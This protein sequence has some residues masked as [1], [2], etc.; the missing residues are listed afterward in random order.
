VND[1]SGVMDLNL[2][3]LMTADSHIGAVY[4][5][6]GNALMKAKRWKT[7]ITDFQFCIQYKFKPGE[8]FLFYHKIGQCY[9]K[10]KFYSKGVKSFETALDLLKSSDLGEKSK[11]EF[12]KILSECIAKFK[13]KKDDKPKCPAEFQPEKPNKQDPIVTDQV[14]VIETI[15]MG[16]NAFAKDN[17][18]V[19][20]VL[21]VVDT[22]AAHLNPDTPNQVM[23]YCLHC[24]IG[25]EVP[26]PCSSCPRVIFC[27][28]QCK[29][30]AE[31]SYHKYECELDLYN[32]RINDSK[33][34]CTIFHS[35]KILCGQPA[36]FWIKNQKEFVG[37]GWSG[38]WPAPVQNDVQRLSLL[39]QM[40]Q[41]VDDVTSPTHARHSLVTIFL[42]RSLR[43]TS[44]YT[45]S[46]LETPSGKL[47]SEEI[48]LGKLIYKLR[49]IQ[50]MNSHPVWG[51][52][53]NQKDKIGSDHIGAGLYSAIGSYFNSDCNPNTFR[54]N[55]GRKMLLIAAKNI[56]KGEEVMD[57]YCIHF[58][59]LPKHIRHPWIKE[60]Y[61]FDCTCPACENDWPTYSKLPKD[62]PNKKVSDKLV[63][64]EM[65]NLDLVGRGEFDK[66]IESHKQEIRLI[67]NAL[68]T[69]HQLHVTISKSFQ[70]CWWKKVVLYL[71]Q[72]YDADE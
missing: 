38:D 47:S 9:V 33:D 3:I 66:A 20:S 5:H 4:F 54:I 16:R 32:I 40:A 1:K 63:Q 68:P 60:H 65:D 46:G 14:E 8:T 52:A 11:S 30:E 10:I 19:G 15:G 69:P 6:R 48:I 72:K 31:E 24:M 43:K 18:Q 44:Y 57:N 67:Q 45:D 36:K 61:L 29:K 62:R 49:L 25:V 71:Q 37:T 34:G 2:G 59:E 7:A 27:G 51:V 26:Y 58:S 22:E 42:L 13:N 41:N 12:T 56:K 53:K 23:K 55:I 35:L 64:L 70:V 21:A 39:F 28:P 50:D 17:I